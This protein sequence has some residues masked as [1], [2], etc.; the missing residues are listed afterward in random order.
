MKKFTVGIFQNREDAEKAINRAHNELNIPTSDLSFIYRNSDGEVKE[1]PAGDIATSTPVEGAGH[2]AAIGGTIGAIAGLATIAGVIPVI[3]PLFAAG[4]LAVALGL[5]GAVGTTAAAAA[6]GAIA[7]GL[8]GALTN[9][10]VGE[11]NAK[12]YAD[13]VQS[14]DVLVAA[15]AEEGVDVRALFTDAG[16]IETEGYALKV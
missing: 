10:G 13:R 6:T 12:R 4:P 11:E 14:G 9:L 3:G 5:T 16:A 8:I 1:V 2:G 7:G 15:Y